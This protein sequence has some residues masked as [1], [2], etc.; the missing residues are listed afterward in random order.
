MLVVSASGRRCR[1]LQIFDTGLNVAASASPPDQGFR[2]PDGRWGR[3]GR[4]DSCSQPPWSAPVIGLGPSP[5]GAGPR[6]SRQLDEPA[7]RTYSW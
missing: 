2:S 6:V 5:R 4:K 3:P 1:R 7:D